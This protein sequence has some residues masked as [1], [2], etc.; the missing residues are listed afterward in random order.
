MRAA[1]PR[2]LGG[3]A[4]L[5]A[6]A[7]G[8]GAAALAA[9]FLLFVGAM[10]RVEP[11]PPP[12]A[13]GV[14]ALTGGADRIAEA[15]DLLARGRADRL[16]ITGVN[17]DTTGPEIARLTPAARGLLDCC[18]ELGYAAA[19]TVGNAAE[20]SRWARRHAIRSLIVVTSDYHMARALAEIGHAA[21]GVELTAF[22]VPSDRGTG[23]RGGGQ[24][25][26]IMLWEYLKY[27]AV[28]ARLHLAPDLAAPKAA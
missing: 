24:R 11:A 5:V 15:V 1:P 10:G 27:L 14:V 21:P 13:E 25:L 28:L 22:P 8:L 20:T 9:G 7:G 12:H 17:P 16:L 4:R 3:L 19:N 2:W 18:I 6:L 23:L 26:R